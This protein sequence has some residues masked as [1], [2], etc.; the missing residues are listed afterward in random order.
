MLYHHGKVSSTC[1]SWKT[2]PLFL[3]YPL[4]GGVFNF[5]WRGGPTETRLRNNPNYLIYLISSDA[6]SIQSYLS[7]LPSLTQIK[8]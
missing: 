7:R 8:L 4:L 5:G 2:K 3:A 6:N 1:L